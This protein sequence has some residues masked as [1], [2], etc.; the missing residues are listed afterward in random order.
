ME[1]GQPCV[2]C[3]SVAAMV[4]LVAACASLA[5]CSRRAAEVT[6]VRIV[7]TWTDVTVDQLEFRV[8]DGAGALLTG[9][10]RRPA[11]P[12]GPLASGADVVIFF[13]EERGGTEVSCEVSGL[14]A[15]KSVATAHAT[16]S[17]VAR[18]V[19][20]AQ[21]AL[22][23]G[24]GALAEGAPCHEGA[25]CGS[26]I[27][28]DG[29]CCRTSCAGSCLSCNVAGKQGTCAPVPEGVKDPM[30]ADQGAET[31]GFEGTCDGRGACRKYPAGTLCG[32]ASCDGSNVTAAGACDGEGHC[33]KGPVVTCAPFSCDPSG[34][35]P[36][37]FSRCRG[38]DECVPGRVC[39]AGS[40][41]SKSNG[42]NCT[43][44]SECT[45]GF[46]AD[47]VCCDFA[48][49]GPCLACAQ[50]GSMGICRPVSEGVKDP[51]GLCNEETASS[52]GLTG[53]C[54]GNGGCARY[55]NGTV[56]RP[57]T[58]S[59]T[60]L[61]SAGRC[62]G[63]GGCV[64]G[65]DLTCAPFGCAGG[66]CNSVCARDQDCA[67]GQVCDPVAHS[68]GKKGQGQ[69]C[70]VGT[71]CQKGFCVDGVCCDSACQGPC[72]SCVLGQTP[73][74]CTDTPAGA[75]DPR[76]SCKDLGASKCDTDGT[77]DG[78]RGCRK[79][80]SGTVCGAG[81]CNATSN[82][83]TLDQVCG[84]GICSPGQTV[85]CGAYR[86]NGAICFNACSSDADCASPNS[87]IGGACTQRGMGAPCSQSAPCAAPLTCIGTTCQLKDQGSVCKI[88]GE[89]SSGHCTDGVCCEN[90]PCPACQSCKVATFVGFCHPL[91]S[92]TADSRCATDPATTCRQDGTCDGAGGCHLYAAGTV[93][94]PA[95]CA[96]Q[97][98][99][100]PRTCDG[101]GACQDS[102]TTDCAPFTCDPSSGNCFTSCSADDQC[103][104]GKCGND[105]ACK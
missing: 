74:R 6:G 25:E 103:C 55:P 61:H 41:G 100:N 52:C 98:R 29:V 12:A 46:C 31:C 18:M 81:S 20:T 58:C 22:A 16:T 49:D 7:T 5:G 57:A 13:G 96:A 26:G 76:G 86:C 105:N 19:T 37:C 83:R 45:S 14:L 69:P 65:G 68:C 89:C 67:P 3:S 62:D 80:P 97:I 73:G 88:D 101:L 92:G 21:V 104:C 90:G 71:E 36:R 34:T 39:V 60:I 70:S 95:S 42:A 84:R 48:C 59:G 63:L 72:R 17:L 8:R 23:P 38:S 56:C 44:A 28:A 40:C 15:G 1:S 93:C 99:T 77:C 30:C 10:A 24:G 82:V 78:R 91:A 102:G 50:P 47:G 66:A 4:A 11:Q 51:R 43:A 35:T 2:R 54:N 94:G 87:C 27:C 85:S 64:A 32:S 9:P 75:V 33:N 79:Y 53:A